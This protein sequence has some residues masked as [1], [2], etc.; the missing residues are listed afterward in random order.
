MG[1][2]LRTFVLGYVFKGFQ[3][4]KG[5]LKADQEL[6]RSHYGWLLFPD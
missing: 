5:V 4:R 1:L 2:P 6:T 3:E